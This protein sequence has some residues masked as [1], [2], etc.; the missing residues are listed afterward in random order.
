[1]PVETGTRIGWTDLHPAVLRKE[2]MPGF[3]LRL[4]LQAPKKAYAGLPTIMHV[5]RV[6]EVG[7]H[8]VYV[9]AGYAKL[10]FMLR[11]P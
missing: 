4:Q 3:G 1:M 7:K 10:K 2:A 8:H 6:Q 11:Q 5:A 9:G